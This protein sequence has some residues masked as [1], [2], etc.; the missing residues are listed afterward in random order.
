MHVLFIFR[1]TKP[2]TKAKPYTEDTK[3]LNCPTMIILRE[4][5]F[6]IYFIVGNYMSF[7]S[8]LYDVR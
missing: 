8:A 5:L 3:K 2:H 1:A 7:S 6:F 4:I